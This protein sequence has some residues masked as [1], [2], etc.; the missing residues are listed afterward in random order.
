M[1]D[2]CQVG[3]I[4]IGAMGGM[5]IN[6]HYQFGDQDAYRLRAASRNK[7]VLAQLTGAHPTLDV[8]EPAEVVEQSDLV[9]VC[10]P[11][12]PYLDVVNALAPQFTAEKTFVCI[13]N[14]VP[15][16]AVGDLV[17][18]PIVKVIPSMAHC[19]G[20]GVSIVTAG[21]RASEND[22]SRVEAFIRPFAMPYRMTETDMRIV[23]NLTGCGPAVLAHFMNILVSVS[24]EKATVVSQA[25]LYRLAGETFFATAQLIENGMTPQEIADEAA[26]G[27]GTTE[28][29]LQTLTKPLQS[30]VAEMI[31]AT[32]AREDSIRARASGSSD[33][34]R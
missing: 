19:I 6:A 10:V 33:D 25:D 32:K 7:D 14:G 8:L 26:T 1:S 11:P 9:F 5:L 22:V 31:A 17:Q 30:A 29:A 16:E 15:V 28:M 3:L 20:R 23:C 13:T 34:K 18:A 4:G 21:P 24:A 12:L 27:G 2:A